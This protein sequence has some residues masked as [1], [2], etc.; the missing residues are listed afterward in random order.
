MRG[1]INRPACKGDNEDNADSW[2]ELDFDVGGEEEAEWRT[3]KGTITTTKIS[4]S[5]RRR[6]QRGG[7]VRCY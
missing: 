1:G 2:D 3:K 6:K 5:R 4:R 7:G